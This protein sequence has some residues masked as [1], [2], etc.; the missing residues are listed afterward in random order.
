MLTA[1][2]LIAAAALPQQDAA[3][4]APHAGAP[5][6]V[7]ILTDDQRADTIHAWGNPHI[8]TPHLDAL[9]AR[10]T[11]FHRA[12]CMGSRGGAVCVPSRAMIHT[13]R[14]FFGLDLGMDDGTPTLGAVLGEAGYAT[15]HTGKWHNGR[16]SVRRSFGRGR[17]IMFS[18]MSNHH[19]VPITHFEEG[20]F[21]E[22]TTG[23]GHSSEIFADA[24][25]A[26]LEERAAEEGG[27]PFFLSVAFSAPHDPRDPPRPWAR[28]YYAEPPPLPRNFLPQH[29][30]DNG[31]LVLRDE[32]L[33]PWPRTAEVVRDQLAEY[34][35][36]I[37]HL[38][39]QIG[40]VLA[41][42]DELDDGREVL[43]V[44]LADHGLALGS[45][46]LL[47]KQS[48]YE[49]SMRAP[50]IVAGPGFPAGASCHA[51]SYLTDVHG[52][53]L[54]AAGVD[55]ERDPRWCRDLGPAARGEET[56]PREELLLA[57]G[58]SQRAL[59]DGR[60]KLIRYPEVDHT[61]LFDLASDSHE[62]F[63]LAARPDQRAR[64]AAMTERLGALMAEAGDR[65]P[66]SV[67]EPRPL[68]RDLSQ[69]ERK[70]DRWQP[71]W[72]RERYF[73]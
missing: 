49:H 10:G 65:A 37:E 41:A 68:V 53:M 39:A 9:S 4:A 56:A 67:A 61:Q 11:S 52:T 22:T 70:P 17:S 15:F 46:G 19:E 60:W 57:M 50:L 6:V 23:V 47:G 8:R 59:S 72:I 31:F 62:L 18:G 14:P 36:L 21:S 51:L 55:F 33:A 45:H 64:V 35:G 12:Y 71:R 63:D 69:V 28:P 58:S 66:L 30:F 24:A 34:Y 42:V 1:L 7:L 26:F 13:G 3:A 5:H 43:V 32:V 38:D 48:V 2:L 44:Y 16:G 25:V 20:E 27:G 54:A 29:P 40:R 73:R